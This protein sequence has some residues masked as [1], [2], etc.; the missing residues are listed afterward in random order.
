MIIP[1]ARGWPSE[2]REKT[3]G[4]TSMTS[5]TSGSKKINWW[6]PSGFLWIKWLWRWGFCPREI[7]IFCRKWWI[8]S[9]F[10]GTFWLMFISLWSLCHCFPF[11]KDSRLIGISAYFIF[12]AMSRRALSHD[13]MIFIRCLVIIAMGKITIFNRW[14]IYFYGPSIPWLC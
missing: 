6:N 5:M 1:L 8:P 2:N 11:G 14:S 12:A 4:M 3:W 13:S 7:G 9:E 10:G